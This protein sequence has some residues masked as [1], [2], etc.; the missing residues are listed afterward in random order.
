MGN[1]RAYAVF[2][3]TDAVTA[4]ARARRLCGLLAERDDEVGLFAEL[5][6][7]A[8]LRRMAEV[9][10]GAE[11]NYAGVRTGPT[12]EHLRFDPDV[13]AAGD[14]VLERHLPLYLL[15]DVPEARRAHR[16][17]GPGRA[18]ARPVTARR[19]GRPRPVAPLRP[20]GRAR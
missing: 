7:V 3:T 16:R 4:Y 17:R 13:A 8:D 9:L 20:G 6:T 12:G 18:A 10:P 11:F 5:E 19:L 14:D 1:S 15:E 2:R